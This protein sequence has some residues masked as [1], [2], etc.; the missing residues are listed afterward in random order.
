[1]RF[2]PERAIWSI[3]VEFQSDHV[4]VYRDQ[5]TMYEAGAV[6]RGLQSDLDTQHLSEPDALCKVH[7]VQGDSQYNVRNVF[8]ENSRLTFVVAA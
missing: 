1:M 2:V 3:R 8:L 5:G 7:T 6:S 4:F